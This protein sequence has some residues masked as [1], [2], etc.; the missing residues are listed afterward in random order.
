MKP[1]APAV[2]VLIFFSLLG[3][4]ESETAARQSAI[5]VRI[6]QGDGAI[7]SIKLKRAHN[8]VVQV[9][10]QAG[11]GVSG[12]TVTFLLPATGAGGTFQ[13]SG[14]SLTVPTDEKGVAAARGL[15]PN[16]LE[17]RFPIRVTASWSGNAASATLLQTNAEPVVSSG[18]GKKIAIIAAIAGGAV[19]GI[20]AG[21][22]GGGSS[23]SSN[24]PP[25]A[26]GPTI[27][28]GTPTIGPP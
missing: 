22:R 4:Q 13:G 5:G 9:V 18:R 1:Y 16:R 8:P 12:A 20:V 11:R 15:T 14:L 7:N 27:V 17:G 28:A 26:T 24:T 23:G 6:L 2:C 21:T 19:A 10:D 3:A 25:P